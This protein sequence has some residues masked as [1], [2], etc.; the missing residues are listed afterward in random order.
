MAVLSLWLKS[1]GKLNKDTV[2]GTVMSNLGFIKFC[3]ANNLSFVATKVGDRFVSEAMHEGGYSLGGE[4]SGHIIFGN[5]EAT[6]DGQ[7]TAVALLSEIKECGKDLSALSKIMKKYPQKTL[8][9]PAG[10]EEKLIFMTDEELRER[11]REKEARI[12]PNGRIVARPSGTEPFIRI[13]VEAES[14]ELL[15]SVI[16]ECKTLLEERF[17][18]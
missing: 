10:K 5:K 6:G 9:F 11:I 1:K 15:K 16:E 4:Q 2:V 8:N 13:T 3:E 14:E 17:P 12:S 7:Y 18:R